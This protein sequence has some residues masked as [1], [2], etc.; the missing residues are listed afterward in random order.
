MGYI[1]EGSGSKGYNSFKND[2]HGRMVCPVCG[3]ALKPK[4][5]TRH[6]RT[7]TYVETVF[8]MPDHERRGTSER[9]CPN[10][11]CNS[12]LR[13]DLAKIDRDVRCPHCG[14]IFFFGQAHKWPTPETRKDSVR[15]L[16]K[17]QGGRL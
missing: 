13:F 6:R 5:Y 15:K 11:D 2:G 14:L 3:V 16:I 10:P 12:K 4:R 7:E 1:C 9:F 8:T 17:V